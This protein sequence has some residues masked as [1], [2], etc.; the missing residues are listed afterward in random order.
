LKIHCIGLKKT[1]SCEKY[2]NTVLN[3]TITPLAAE[4]NLALSHDE[5]DFDA[6]LFS[7]FDTDA[8]DVVCSFGAGKLYN[9]FKAAHDTNELKYHPRP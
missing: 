3:S 4:F 9:E 7:T 1:G 5:A 6:A 2:F 8:T